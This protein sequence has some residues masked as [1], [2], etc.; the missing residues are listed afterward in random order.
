MS[1]TVSSSLGEN[2]WFTEL[3]GLLLLLPSATVP[4]AARAALS[5]AG[6][7]KEQAHSGWKTKESQMVAEAGT[8]GGQEEI[9]Q[10]PCL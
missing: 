1:P 3:L 9:K 10:N 2:N 5:A 4:L 8:S 6:V 7:G